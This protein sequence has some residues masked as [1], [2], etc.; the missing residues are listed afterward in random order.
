MTPNDVQDDVRT[1]RIC[2]TAR[3][4]TAKQHDESALL[5]ALS[6][7]TTT[8]CLS[9]QL[10]STFDHSNKGKYVILNDVYSINNRIRL[11]AIP[12]S[13]NGPSQFS[14]S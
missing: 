6:V 12:Y 3:T 9:A 1:S 10:V 2:R 8:F 7:L 13:S 5:I 11:L 14:L 4:G